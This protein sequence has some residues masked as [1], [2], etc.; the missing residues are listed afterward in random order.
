M[1][2]RALLLD[3][4][5]TLNHDPGYLNDPGLVRL[6]PGVL[7]GLTRLK[8]AG[9]QFFVLTNQSG[10]ARGLIS[11][12][13]LSSVNARITELLAESGILIEKFYVCPHSDED[14]CGC[15]KPLPGLV[16]AFL[17]DYPYT[18]KDCFIVGDKLRDIEAAEG[19]GIRGILLASAAPENAPGN[20][21]SC[22]RDLVDAAATILEL[23]D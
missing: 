23:E 20:L 1:R 18:A 17:A 15:R 9:F 5:E 13:Q 11:K 2:K 8:K 10:V 19:R 7:E 12:D 4:D 6:L 16:E 3:R 22:A 14:K 21:I